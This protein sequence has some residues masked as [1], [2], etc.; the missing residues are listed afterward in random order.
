MKKYKL[1]K[2]YPKSPPLGTEMEYDSKLKVYVGRVG[3]D[4]NYMISV[5]T[6]EHFPEFWEKQ[7][8]V[9]SQAFKHL[10]INHIKY[11]ENL[12]QELKHYLQCLEKGTFN[13]ADKSMLRLI[14]EDLEN[15]EEFAKQK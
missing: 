2:K 9:Q 11:F 8:G 13:D 4:S 10:N 5:D 12:A 15:L 7:I 6:V 14:V 3:N 1:I